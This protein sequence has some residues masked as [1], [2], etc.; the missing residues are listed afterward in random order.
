MDVG[1]CLATE[2]LALITGK[3]K[4]VGTV[5]RPFLVERES[6][7]R[8]KDPRASNSPASVPGPDARVRRLSAAS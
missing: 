7:Q 8:V 4:S 2:L 1:Q 3:A 5:I 6:H